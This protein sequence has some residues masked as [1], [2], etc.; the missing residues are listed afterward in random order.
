[1]GRDDHP[2]EAQG[3]MLKSVDL[4]GYAL[5]GGEHWSDKAIRRLMRKLDIRQLGQADLKHE[6]DETEKLFALTGHV[7][8]L[9]V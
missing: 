5:A 7:D 6:Y 3:E 8:G 4:L 9:T 2:E 1:M